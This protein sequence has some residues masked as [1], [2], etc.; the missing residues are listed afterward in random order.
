MTRNARLSIRD[1][2]KEV[3]PGNEEERKGCFGIYLLEFLCCLVDQ[4][5]RPGQ[6]LLQEQPKNPLSINLLEDLVDYL[7]EVAKQMTQP[8][9]STADA[10]AAKAKYLNVRAPLLRSAEAA[11]SQLADDAIAHSLS[12]ATQIIQTMSECVM[13]PCERNQLFLARDTKVLDVW[14]RMW[15]VG[16]A[17]AVWAGVGGVG[18]DG[19]TSGGHLQPA[20]LAWPTAVPSRLICVDALHEARDRT[21]PCDNASARHR[22]TIT[23]TDRSTPRR[24]RFQAQP[25]LPADQAQ[26]GRRR[27]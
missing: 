6:L 15:P 3:G 5:F 11:A 13:G 22:R 14:N 1:F 16:A 27:A 12:T 20:R 8:T 9:A 21:A 25:A 10:Q 17:R 26:G 23:C 18:T 4:N 24:H 2:A 7:T 19:N